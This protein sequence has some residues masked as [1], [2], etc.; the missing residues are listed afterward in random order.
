MKRMIL[1]ASD[2]FLGALYGRS[3]AVRA[4]KMSAMAITRAGIDISSPFRPRG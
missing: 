2:S 3:A 1:S 4:S